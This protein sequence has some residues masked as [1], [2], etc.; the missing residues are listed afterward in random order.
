MRTGQRLA[1]QQQ[2]GNVEVLA[3]S[4]HDASRIYDEA[5]AGVWSWRDRRNEDPMSWRDSSRCNRDLLIVFQVWCFRRRLISIVR[6]SAWRDRSAFSD[7]RVLC[8]SSL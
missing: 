4:C 5:D 3:R 2:S 6:L 7:A 1:I 8:V